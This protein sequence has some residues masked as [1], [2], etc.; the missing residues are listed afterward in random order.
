MLFGASSH[1][2]CACVFEY[3]NRG[4]GYVMKEKAIKWVTAN[5]K[6]L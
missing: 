1:N 3:V 5:V 6:S 2:N 4:T